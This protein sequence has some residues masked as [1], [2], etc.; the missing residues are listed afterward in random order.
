MVRFERLTLLLHNLKGTRTE[1]KNY[2]PSLRL[3]WEACCDTI[4]LVLAL[5]IFFLGNFIDSMV[6]SKK[7]GSRNVINQG[8]RGLLVNE[9][10]MGVVLTY[11]SMKH[12]TAWPGR[13]SSYLL[14]SS[15][16]S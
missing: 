16:C 7:K 1:L 4:Y 6:F 2:G 12:N 10:A 9:L 14:L 15:H 5:H 11:E 8:Q 13:A 3:I